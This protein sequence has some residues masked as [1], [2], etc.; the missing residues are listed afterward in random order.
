[1]IFNKQTFEIT[2]YEGYK[3]L[4]LFFFFPLENE[5]ESTYGLESNLVLN[6]FFS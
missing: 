2:V 1:M 3:D 5:I 6:I 4:I